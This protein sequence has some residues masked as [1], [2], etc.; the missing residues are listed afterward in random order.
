MINQHYLIINHNLI[1]FMIYND[2]LNIMIHVI[3]HQ[4]IYTQGIDYMRYKK[5]NI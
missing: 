3:A 5:V 4:I 2:S 1:M